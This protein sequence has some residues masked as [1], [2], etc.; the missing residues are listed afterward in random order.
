[1]PVTVNWKL[2]TVAVLIAA[3]LATVPVHPVT[4]TSSVQAKDAVIGIALRVD[5]ALRRRRDRD[6][7]RRLAM[8]DP[9]NATTARTA[10]STTFHGLIMNTLWKSKISPDPTTTLSTRTA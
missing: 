10:P 7:R 3:P 9:G 8:A 6:G 1:M 4:A 5:V 2:P